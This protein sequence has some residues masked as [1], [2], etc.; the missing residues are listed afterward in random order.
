MTKRRRGFDDL[1]VG[2]LS[3]WHG[4]IPDAPLLRI[5]LWDFDVAGLVVKVAGFGQ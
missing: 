1:E 2:E 4:Y 5:L 3:V